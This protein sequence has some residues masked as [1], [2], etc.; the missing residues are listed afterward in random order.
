MNKWAETSQSLSQHSAS[1]HRHSALLNLSVTLCGLSFRLELTHKTCSILDHLQL[2]ILTDS[3]SANSPSPPPPTSSNA[4][5]PSFSSSLMY[6]SKWSHVSL[7][8]TGSSNLVQWRVC[9]CKR[10]KHGSYLSVPEC[11]MCCCISHIFI[12]I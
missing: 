4:F 12:D 2:S 11:V 3:I 9:V 8:T 5:C 10:E 7:H 1:A 6:S